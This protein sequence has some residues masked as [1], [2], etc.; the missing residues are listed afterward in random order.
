MKGDRMVKRLN[1]NLFAEGASAGGDGTGEGSNPVAAEQGRRASRNPLADVAYGIQ[2]TAEESAAAEQNGETTEESFDSLI[3]GKYKQDYDA[4][5]QKIINRRFKET[6]TLEDE[7]KQIAPILTA[8]ADKYGKDPKD[9][10]GIIESMNLDD[11][12]FEARAM[13]RGMTPA[14]YRELMSVQ[15]ENQRLRDAQEQAEQRIRTEQI[16]NGWKAEAEAMRNLYPNLDFDTEMQNPNVTRLLQ[17]GVPFKGAFEAAHMQEIMEGTIG[18]AVQRTKQNVVQN[19]Q[20]R[21][22]RPVE[23]GVRN[24]ATGTIK[25]DVSKLTKADRAEIVRRAAEG[26]KIRF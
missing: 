12:I 23:N 5:V 8:L 2:D 4:S 24:Q 1:L 25:Q 26:V 13:E 18:Y 16:I 21:N 20:S 9:I 14:Q 15:S 10:K 19:I 7:K 3:K 6:K 22:Q 17:A 11:S